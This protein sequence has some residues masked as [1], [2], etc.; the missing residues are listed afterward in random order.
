[1]RQERGKTKV[2]EHAQGTWLS[3]PKQERSED[4]AGISTNVGEL[5]DHREALCWFQQRVDV[6]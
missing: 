4:L 5:V 3:A 6:K 1:M 2:K